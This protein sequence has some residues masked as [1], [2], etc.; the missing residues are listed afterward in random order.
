MF[1]PII[2]WAVAAASQ[3]YRLSFRQIIFLI[4]FAIYSV[5]VLS[6]LSQIARR[7]TPETAD[8]M[9]RLE[10]SIALLS[11]PLRLHQTYVE[12]TARD[13]STPS[14]TQG[15]FDTSQGLL[16]RLNIIK[17]DDR[18]INYTV[19]GHTVGSSRAFYYFLN[20]IP[21][22]ILP[23][24]ESYLP[25]GVANPG[26]YYAHEVGG[27]LS[28]DDFSTG[29]SFSPTAEAFH[30][31][32]WMGIVLVGGCVWTL[33]FITSEV[34]CGDLRRSPYG[35]FAMVAF[36]HF[37]PESLIGGVVYYIF[38]QNVAIVIAILFCSYFAPVLGTLLAGNANMRRYGSQPALLVDATP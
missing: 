26:N 34:V 38:F 18:L 6:P 27:L 17:Q 28:P 25:P 33:L 35:L 13:L 24:K 29:I 7:D 32:M 10:F 22:F 5:T 31:D 1:T 23:N 19:Q 37:A 21:H 15:Y 4:A 8:R 16:D 12:A 9:E 36:A 11:H 3:R 14:F 2:C 30:M 20:W